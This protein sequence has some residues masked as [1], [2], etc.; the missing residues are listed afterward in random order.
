MAQQVAAYRVEAKGAAR[1]VA[2]GGDGGAQ[3]RAERVEGRICP[4]GG[5]ARRVAMPVHLLLLLLLL[6]HETQL[7]APAVLHR[8]RNDS[9]VKRPA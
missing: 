7:L 8:A 1:G 9:T 3:R 2:V 5:V 4:R 6:L